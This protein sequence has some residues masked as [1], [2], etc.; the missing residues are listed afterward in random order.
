MDFKAERHFLSDGTIKSLTLPLFLQEDTMHC[1]SKAFSKPAGKRVFRL[2]DYAAIW[3]H[4]P[5]Q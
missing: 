2:R 4:S 3:R 5:A 1:I